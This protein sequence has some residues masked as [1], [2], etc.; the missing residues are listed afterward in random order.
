M[1]WWACRLFGRSV[2]RSFGPGPER[3]P[4]RGHSPTA[5]TSETMKRGQCSGHAHRLW[6]FGKRSFFFF[7]L[8]FT[9][10]RSR[11]WNCHLRE[12]DAG[13]FYSGDQVISGNPRGYFR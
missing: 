4:A 11:V 13:A 12:G 5:K 6:I 2:V 8:V 9:L 10:G 7:F 1:R 3:R